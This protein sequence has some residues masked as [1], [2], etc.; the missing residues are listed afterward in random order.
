M[1]VVLVADEAVSSC[2]LCQTM[3]RKSDGAGDADVVSV[4]LLLNNVADAIVHFAGLAAGFGE[5]VV[6]GV[7]LIVDGDF[8]A[9][10]GRCIV[11]V[12]GVAE[13]AAEVGGLDLAVGNYV[14][15]RDRDAL[16]E[17][18]GVVAGEAHVALG[19]ADQVE[20]ELDVDRVANQSAVAQVVAEFADITLVVIRIIEAVV[21]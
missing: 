1:L 18:V 14:G 12:E 4:R 15:G 7:H 8:E 5:V 16:V 11:V 10:V 2:D 13:E 20:A 19:V 6:A 3:L 21:D 17:V 9:G